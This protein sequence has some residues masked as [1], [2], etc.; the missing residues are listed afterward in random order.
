MKFQERIL[1]LL[2]KYENVDQ[3]LI[4]EYSSFFTS[5]NKAPLSG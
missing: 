2:N 4:D 5:H 1:Y 3:R